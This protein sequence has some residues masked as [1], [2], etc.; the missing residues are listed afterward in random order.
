MSSPS[1]FRGRR[2]TA[3]TVPRGE[4]VGTFET[5][6]E[7]QAAVDRLAKAEFPVDKVSILGNDLKSVERV[8][9]RLSYGRAALAGALSGLWFGLFLGLLFFLFSPTQGLSV[10]LAAILIGAAFGMLFGLVTYAVQRR[11][12]D[13]VSSVQVLASSYQIIVSPELAARA[14][15]LLER[16]AAP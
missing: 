10:L 13:Y 16:P 9:G 7:A 14:Q 11:S 4:V 3:P 5:Y 2:P 8:T 12:H 15:T 1:L 6:P